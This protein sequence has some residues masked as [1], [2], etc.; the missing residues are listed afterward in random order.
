MA[1]SNVEAFIAQLQAQIDSIVEQNLVGTYIHG[2]L[3]L[4]G[5]NEVSSDIDFIVVTKKALSFDDK[6]Q[7][8]QLFLAASTN[9]F[10]IEISV[11]SLA[12]LETWRH[13]CPFDYHYSEYWRPRYTNGYVEQQ[14]KTDIDLAAHITIM[15]HCGICFKG[16][17][18]NQVFPAVPK[19]HYVQSILSDYND[20][21]EN[22]YNQPVYCILN[23]LR[24]YLYLNDCT[25]TS[26]QQAGEWAAKN[27]PANFTTTAYKALTAYQS[28]EAALNFSPTELRSFKHYIIERTEHFLR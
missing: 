22:I 6:Q 10:P 15:N 1:S 8:T 16:Q 3:A 20:C 9:P 5:F 14:N 13:P 21:L 4:G 28:N 2:S 11:L 24:V 19:Q 23:L 12:Q 27:L 17:P 25:I 26:K 7:L 18:I